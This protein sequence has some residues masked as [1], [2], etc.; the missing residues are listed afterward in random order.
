MHA[1]GRTDFKNVIGGFR[2]DA[3]APKKLGFYK[4]WTIL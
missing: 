3:D 1:D 4:R 2:D